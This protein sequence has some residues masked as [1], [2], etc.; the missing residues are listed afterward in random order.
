MGVSRWSDLARQTG[1]DPASISR[2]R[3]DPKKPLSERERHK[4]LRCLAGRFDTLEA[5]LTWLDQ[6]GWPLHFG[7]QAFLS[8]MFQEMAELPEVYRLPTYLVRR[9]ELEQQLLQALHTEKTPTPGA[10]PAVGVV[11]SGIGGI[12]KTTLVRSALNTHARLSLRFP[13]G[14]YWINCTCLGIEQ[15]IQELTSELNLPLSNPSYSGLGRLLRQTL[16]CKKVLVVM[17]GV[18]NYRTVQALLDLLPNNQSRFIFTTRQQIFS[19]DL[20]RLRLTLI[21]PQ[22]L[23]R[24]QALQMVETILKRTVQGIERDDLLEVIERLEGHPLALETSAMLVEATALS[25]KQILDRLKAASMQSLGDRLREC[26]DITFDSL[27]AAD[28]NAA[29]YFLSLGVFPRPTGLVSIL[30]Q[31]AGLGESESLCALQ[32]LTQYNLVRVKQKD[33]N[34]VWETHILLSDYASDRLAK[35]PAIHDEIYPRYVTAL[36]DL[37]ASDRYVTDPDIAEDGWGPLITAS[38]FLGEE[39]CSIADKEFQHGNLANALRL[40]TGWLS[41]VFYGYHM[42]TLGQVVAQADQIYRQVE[43]PDPIIAQILAKANDSIAAKLEIFQQKYDENFHSIEDE[44]DIRKKLELWQSL[45]FHIGICAGM[46]DRYDALLNNILAILPR[47]PTQTQEK[48]HT[49]IL[50]EKGDLAFIRGQ[51]DQGIEY[52]LRAGSIKHPDEL[53]ECHSYKT[54]HGIPLRCLALLGKVLG[55]LVQ[56]DAIDKILDIQKP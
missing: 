50:H 39:I 30:D 28:S 47:L 20:A 52:Y 8:S 24:D 40:L 13:D 48:L 54:L 43:A 32:K 7:D 49:F 9:P 16:R 34:R 51:R 29:R 31:S 27:A 21:E 5:M 17:D 1:L 2:A 14:I 15:I 33:G 23:T 10:L 38:F 41:I 3:R 56:D 42:A 25:W 22:R 37:I 36:I 4:L 46:V 11:V 53:E 35:L 26:F 19:V 6:I 12:G 55:A 44:H 45:N 18:E